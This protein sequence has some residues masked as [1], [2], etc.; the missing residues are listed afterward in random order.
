MVGD[1]FQYEKWLL[2][3][4]GD[5]LFVIRDEAWFYTRPVL[6]GS[7]VLDKLK[8]V[9]RADLSIEVQLLEKKYGQDKVSVTYLPIADVSF[10]HFI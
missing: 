7:T 3:G 1:C 8:T 10:L 6:S 5:K 9:S 4:T 2:N